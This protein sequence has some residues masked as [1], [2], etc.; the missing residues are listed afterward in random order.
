MKEKSRIVQFRSS[1]S[2]GLKLAAIFLAIIFMVAFMNVQ[3]TSSNVKKVNSALVSTYIMDVAERYTDEVTMYQKSTKNNLDYMYMMGVLNKLYDGISCDGIEGSYGYALQVSDG[4]FLYHPNSDAIGNKIQKQ[5]ILN[6][7]IMVQNGDVTEPQIVT[8]Y[9]GDKKM[10]AAMAPDEDKKFVTVLVAEMTKVEAVVN[11]A[12]SKVVIFDIIIIIVAAGLAGF[13]AS[14]FAKPIK[15]IASEVQRCA[16]L[17]FSDSTVL[18]KCARRKDE[19][20]LVG[21]AVE[22]LRE[23]LKETV[24]G[25]QKQ[26]EDI[27]KAAVALDER[28]TGVAAI[29]EEVRASMLE[30]ANGAQNQVQDAEEVSEKVTVMGDEI[31]NTNNEVK[32]LNDETEETIKSSSQAIETLKGLVETSILSQKA[33]DKVYEQT[34]NTNASVQEIRSATAIITNIAD[35]TNL[36]ALN[37][38]IEAARAGD[39][40]RGFAVVADQIQKL[41]EQSTASAVQID[42][43]IKILL[44]DSAEMVKT[45]EEVIEIMKKQ[46]DDSNT[47]RESMAEA[48]DKVRE[49]LGAV[50]R[51]FTATDN[52]DQSRKVVIEKVE[53]LA[54][55]SASNFD[56]IENTNAGVVRVDEAMS[57]ISSEAGAL[58]DIADSLKASMDKFIL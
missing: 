30:V 20:G 9:E 25:I 7:L 36:L 38:S 52:M 3:M 51:I 16:N 18:N 28:V 31:L 53:N 49:S 43:V 6:Y 23:T 4:M 37:A 33:V 10:Y 42:E 2:F 57:E 48:N 14:R 44:K 35:E 12:V 21:K 56:Y 45:M 11:Q 32:S 29:L 5:E 15:N 22:K 54:S 41:A 47:T 8:Y 1:H 58:K 13:A 50:G 46:Q 39:A 34:N 55:I 26:S 40:G 27:T 19:I 24:Y 17:D